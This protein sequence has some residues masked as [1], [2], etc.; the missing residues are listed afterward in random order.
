MPRCFLALG[1]NVGAVEQTFDRALASLDAQS[2]LTVG[3]TSKM[4][5]FPAVG[6]QAGTEFCNAAAEL[7]TELPPFHLLERLQSVEATFGRL[8][9][10]QWGPR[11]LDLDLILYGS[12]IIDERQLQ[13]PHPACWYRRFVLDPLVDIAA[14]RVHPGKSL[15]FGALR[16]RLLVRPL[17]VALAGADRAIR[18]HEIAELERHFPHVEFR[19]WTTQ[20]AAQPEPTLLFWLGSLQQTG[21]PAADFRALP[22]GPRLDASSAGTET[23]RFLAEVVQSA[24]GE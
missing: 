24:L 11:T 4:H 23:S 5:R 20:E 22:A 21:D 19:D 18:M 2:D 9:D 16:A 12:R 1:G 10:V 7:N 6:R 3:H 14:D 8:R 15:S 17:R 13:V